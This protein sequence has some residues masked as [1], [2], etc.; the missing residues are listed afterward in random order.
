MENSAD[1][2]G[3]PRAAWRVSTKCSA[4]FSWCPFF[5]HLDGVNM[6]PGLPVTAILVFFCF[7]NQGVTR[8]YALLAKGGIKYACISG[9]DYSGTSINAALREVSYESKNNG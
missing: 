5:V 3:F 4:G 9:R 6:G 1:F 7:V 2:S 8:D